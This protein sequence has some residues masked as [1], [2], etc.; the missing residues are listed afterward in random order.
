MLRCAAPPGSPCTTRS[1]R[2][3]RR[4]KLCASTM[5]ADMALAWR[6]SSTVFTPCVPVLSWMA[7]RPKRS[8][9]TCP[10]MA[11]SG[12]PSR[13]AE[14]TP[15]SALVAPGPAVTRHTP[16]LPVARA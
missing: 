12:T 15:V 7:L 1:T 9:A 8:V 10:L 6:N 14:A 16:S 11:S 13:C 3:N 2:A 5:P 4:W